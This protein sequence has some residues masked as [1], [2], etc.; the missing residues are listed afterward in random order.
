MRVNRV[1]SF[2]ELV[3]AVNITEFD[4]TRLEKDSR[5]NRPEKRLVEL[6]TSVQKKLDFPKPFNMPKKDKISK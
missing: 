1:N 2:C 3:D 6:K 5:E 4:F